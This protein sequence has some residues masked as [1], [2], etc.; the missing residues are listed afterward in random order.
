MLKD[1]SHRSDGPLFGRLREQDLHDL[2]YLK[3]V[4]KDTEAVSNCGRG[5]DLIY[6][7]GKCSRSVAKTYWAV[8][9]GIH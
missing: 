7:S 8:S 5:F 1:L 6:V 3:S 9:T 4:E 2:L